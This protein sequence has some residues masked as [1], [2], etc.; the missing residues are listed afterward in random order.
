MLVNKGFK[1]VTLHKL[2]GIRV[3]NEGS[4]EIVKAFNV[5]EIKF[6]CFDEIYNF[7]VN[8]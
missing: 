7:S 3:N 4:E 5:E 8:L 1:V 2:L 6:I